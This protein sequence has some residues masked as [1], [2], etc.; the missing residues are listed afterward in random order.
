MFVSKKY[1]LHRVLTDK[2]MSFKKAYNEGGYYIP[3]EDYLNLKRKEILYINDCGLIYK[4]II[5]NTKI[6][7]SSLLINHTWFYKCEVSYGCN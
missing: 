6:S 2:K 7:W 5:P 4:I 3:C 1:H